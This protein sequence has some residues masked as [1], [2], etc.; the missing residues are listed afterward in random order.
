MI[1]FYE[2]YVST[3]YE[4]ELGEEAISLR[5]GEESPDVGMIQSNRCAFITACNP[6]SRKV[7]DADNAE[8]MTELESVLRNRGYDYYEGLGVPDNDDWDPEPSYLVV[9]VSK[10]EAVELGR[11]FGQNAVVYCHAD[12][13]PT[14]LDCRTPEEQLSS[15]I[16]GNTPLDR[17][18][19]ALFAR[20]LFLERNQQQVRFSDNSHSKD[21]NVAPE[22]LRRCGLERTAEFIRPGPQD[23]G[24]L[25][26]TLASDLE[27]RG[28]VDQVATGIMTWRS[29]WRQE[30]GPWVHQDWDTFVR[31]RHGPKVGVDILDAGTAAFVKSLNAAGAATL[32]SCAGRTHWMRGPRRYAHGRPT[33]TFSGPYFT[34]WA[35]KVFQLLLIPGG[36]TTEENRQWPRRRAEESYFWSDDRLV[37]EPTENT[38]PH[39]WLVPIARLIYGNRRRLRS[40]CEDVTARVDETDAEAE[41]DQRLNRLEVSLERTLNTREFDLTPWDERAEIDVHAWSRGQSELVQND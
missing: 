14:L 11:K 36:T 10:D 12:G 8:R 19:S 18:L 20:G 27:H 25:R 17:L 24:L 37:V 34:W 41:V 40:I 1:N 9:D 6:R 2:E 26:R 32:L 4:A 5:V 29:H 16:V 3:S 33:I 39:T 31:R 23:R 21:R 13:R 38:Q 15:L 22:L 28:P 7:S 30:G 35:K